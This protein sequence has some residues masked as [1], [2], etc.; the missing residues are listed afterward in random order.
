V[1]R[2]MFVVRLLTIWLAAWLH[3]NDNDVA[4]M[5]L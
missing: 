2:V 3:A 5:S 1:R 4:L